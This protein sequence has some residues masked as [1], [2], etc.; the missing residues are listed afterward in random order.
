MAVT[1]YK[2]IKWVKAA[3]EIVVAIILIVFGYRILFGA[4]PSEAADKATFQLLVG[5]LWFLVIWCI[6]AAVRNII[7]SLRPEPKESLATMN[8]RIDALDRKLIIMGLASEKIPDAIPPS[9]EDLKKTRNK[10]IM[11]AAGL[12]AAIVVLAAITTVFLMTMMGGGGNP[13][14]GATPDDTLTAL[15][16]AMNA[17][18]ANGVLSLTVY[19][20]GNETMKG[21]FRQSLNG[22]FSMAGDTFHVTMNSHQVKYPADLNASENSDLTGIQNE[23]QNRISNTVTASCVIVYNMTITTNQSSFFEDGNMPCFQIDGGWYILMDFGDGG[24]DDGGDRQSPEQTFLGFIE[25]LNLKDALGAVSFTVAM[26]GS[27]TEQSQTGDGISSMW[28]GSASFSAV[29]DS[30]Q[31]RYW[32]SLNMTEQ[33]NLSSIQGD[34]SSNYGVTITDSCFVQYM[35]TITNDSGPR[36]MTG[37]MACFKIDN[38]WYLKLEEP[39]GSQPDY[40]IATSWNHP[41]AFFI[42]SVDNIAG[43]GSSININDVYLTV[44]YANSTIAIGHMQLSMMPAGTPINGTEFVETS[45]PGTLDA[46][47]YF[48]L[49]DMMFGPGTKLILENAMAS[50]KYCDATI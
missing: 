44:I 42:L 16:A 32:S 25:N 45:G 50:Q 34:V 46:G 10:K 27:S 28:Q 3:F 40:T 4:F 33:N 13:A 43:V 36:Q 1:K 20:F 48:S 23:I 41:G 5:L 22:M 18:D 6:I 21:Q 7:L 30:P 29:A 31:V 26:F 11:I 24:P 39:G 49:D 8:E 9:P 47:D 35:I 12:V 14:G 19:S 17:K 15:I 2:A 37:N 38:Q